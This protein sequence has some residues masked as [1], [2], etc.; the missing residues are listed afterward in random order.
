MRKLTSFLFISLDGVVESP[1]TFVRANVYEDFPELIRESIAEQDAVLLGRKTYQEWSTFW[2]NSKI[3]PFASFINGHPKF[4]VSGTLSRLEWTHSTLLGRDLAGAVGE[5]KAQ[6]GK[7]IGVHG[8]SLIQS[9]LLAGLLD[10]MRFIQC[11]VIAGHGRRL[12]DHPGAAL[13]LDLRHS[14]A[15]PTGLQYSIY[16]PR[17]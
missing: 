11:P 8:I 3:E 14:R 5:L 17:R 9:L 13:Q 7:A 10:E 15:T 1:D 6:P 12:L 2:P 4:V 16:T